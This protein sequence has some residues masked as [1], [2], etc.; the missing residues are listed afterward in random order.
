MT[1]NK[2]QLTRLKLILISSLVVI[3]IIAAKQFNLYE[4]LQTSLTWVKSLGFLGT[5]VFIAIYNVATL[6]FVPGSLLTVKGGCLF[7]IVWGSV[8][9]LIAATLGAI[10]AFLLGRYLSRDWVCRKLEKNPQFQ[11]I[12][13]AVAKKGW[14][15]VLLTRL[16]PIFPFNLLNYAFG[17]TQVSLKDYIL[18]SVGMIPATV[19]YVYIGSL[20][21]DLATLDMSNLP[22]TATTQNLQWAIRIM[23]LM[24][25]IAVT[26]YI[27]RLAKKA[28][29][30][31]IQDGEIINA[32]TKNH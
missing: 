30:Q 25:T 22:T 3:L 18:G 5:L 8:Y 17:V 7:G 32:S 1:K 27:T 16:S 6:L 15:I 4:L 20:A 10:W 2:G 14:K 13:R 24:A 29:A 19:V 12:D 11:A 9:V 26:I 23:G 31:N 21:T 28:L